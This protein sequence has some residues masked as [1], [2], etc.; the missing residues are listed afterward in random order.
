MRYRL[1][2]ITLVAVLFLM[3]TSLFALSIPWTATLDQS[4]VVPPPSSVPGAIGSASG[5]LDDITNILSWNISW[6]GLSSLPTVGFF[7][8]PAPPG[9]NAGVQ[10]NFGAISGLTSPSIGSTT[11]SAAQAADLL[12]GLWYINIH[13]VQN[14]AGEIRGQVTPA[15]VPEPSTL[16]LLGIGLVGLIGFRRKVRN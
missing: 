1:A 2:I 4:Q 5:A 8:G 11:I 7:H 16:F 10:V 3:P 12:A 14:P 15:S 6:S 9:A 13:T